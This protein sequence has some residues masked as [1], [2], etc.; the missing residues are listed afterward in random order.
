MQKLLFSTLC[1][2]VRYAV[3]YRDLE[4]ILEEKGVKVD[5]VTIN[6]EVVRYS[7]SLARLLI[8]VKRP[9]ETSWHMDVHG[10]FDSAV[11][12]FSV[13]LNHYF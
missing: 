1:F 9:T 13:Q 10:F 12:I 4:E 3:A 2:Y 8:I 6:R 5:N 11:D 7:S